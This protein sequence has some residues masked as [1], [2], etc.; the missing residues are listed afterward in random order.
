[1]QTLNQFI[2][3][4]KITCTAD[5]AD[6][7]PNMADDWP[8]NHYRCVLKMGKRRMTVPFSMGLGLTA[9]PGA[10][11]VLDAL[12]SDAAGVENAGSFE[13]WCGEYGYEIDSRKAERIFKVCQRQAI[14]LKK[15]LG[16]HEDYQALLFDTERK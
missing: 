9:E 6:S 8:A 4:H 7:N 14:A 1:M 13:D 2:A 5:Y 15:F 16:N 12:A 3:S 10:D 11:D